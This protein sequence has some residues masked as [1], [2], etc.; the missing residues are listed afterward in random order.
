MP[1]IGQI[2]QNRVLTNLT[3]EYR[4]GPYISTEV[5]PRVPVAQESDIYYIYDFSGFEIPET[6]REPRSRYNQVDW[7]VSTDTY[8]AQEYGLEQPI[9]DRERRNAVGVLDLERDSTRNLTAQ[10]LNARERRVANLA[11]A[12]A[13]YP[14]GHTITL[15]GAAQWSDPV[16]SDPVGDVAVARK[17]IQ[18]ATGL[19]PNTMVMGYAVFEALLAHEQIRGYLAEGGLVT[20]EVLAKIF[21]LE[22][23][24][25]GSVLYNTAKEGQATTLGDLWGFDVVIFHRANT[26]PALR[27]PS[28][29]YQFVAADF[30]VFQYRNE[31]ITSDI[32]RVNEITAE[33]MVAPKLG[34]LYK[35]A[36]AAA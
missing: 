22:R 6:L 15:A 5:A 35:A 31:E 13:S 16:N 25:V 20:E 36:A 10:L 14:A 28:F 3:V 2:R 1:L 4:P 32:I 12:T 17:K 9:D 7:S 11:T 19:L 29:M 18:S 33:K 34:F 21:R 30:R 24:V 23:V 26:S 8:F 27:T